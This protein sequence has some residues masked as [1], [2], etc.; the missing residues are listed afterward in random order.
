M[1]NWLLISA[2]VLLL[3]QF[4]KGW[5][6][7][8]LVPGEQRSLTSFFDLVLFFNAGAAFSFLADAGGWQRI[9]F[10]VFA[11]VASVII[12]RLLHQHGDRPLFCLALS[13]VLGGALGNLWDRVLLGHVVDFLYFHYHAY[14][15]PAFNIADTAIS[16]GVLLLL[17]DGLK[18]TDR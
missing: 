9:F 11:L 4:S 14:Y 16:I 18:K 10:S 6:Q 3:D 15:W 17:L 12:V 1:R 2:A 5:V 7:A 13:L 8:V